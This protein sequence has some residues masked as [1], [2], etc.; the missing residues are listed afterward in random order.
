MSN[1]AGLQEEIKWLQDH[2]EFE[3]RPATLLEFLG[4]DYLGIDSKVRGSIKR[5]L[6]IIM[7]EE[8]RADRPT[9][10][11]LAMITG[12]I[13]IGKTTVAS[14]VLPYLCHWVLCLK[15]P[16][17]FFGLLPG[18][19]IAFMQM[20]T[21]EQQAR[22]VVFGDIFARIRH[23]PWFMNKYPFDP[24]FTKSVRFEKD[25]WILPGD[26]A[27]TTFEGYNIL[28][29]IL[30]EAD[31]HKVTKN[32][33][34]ADSG[35][36]TISARITSRFEDKGFLLVIGQ[37]KKSVGFAASK[38]EEF[39]ARDDAYAV[40]MAIWESMGWE[41]YADDD[42]HVETFRYDTKRKMVVPDGVAKH[43]TYTT[44]IIEIPMVFK[45]DFV[46]NPE[47]ALRDLAGIPPVVGDPFISLV[48]KIEE[49]SGRWLQRHPHTDGEG[50]VDP[51][52]RIRRWFKAHD[53]LK[54][55][56]HIDLAYSADGDHLGF[57][58]GHVREMI[59]VED[60]IKPYIIIDMLLRM[61]APSGGEIYLG[62]VRR[63]VYELRDK[64]GF[65]L[66][67]ISM[68]GFESTDTK[69]QFRRKRIKSDIVSIDRDVLPYHDLREAIYEDR[70]EFPPYLVKYHPNDGQL[71]EVVVKE[72]MELVDEG[73][74]IDHPPDGSKDVADAVAG[75]THHLMGDR[76]YHKK[77][78]RMADH[79][80]R[81]AAVGDGTR[82]LHPAMNPGTLPAPIPPDLPDWARP[83]R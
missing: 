12:G 23:S 1:L 80:A 77:V 32:K 14:I 28:G 53:S 51:E 70:I 78:V 49:C 15:D 21:S 59:Q 72:L 9:E 35:Y 65:K 24:K 31:S 66:D 83:P 79:S 36:T 43:T 22:E 5:E 47:K 16:Q 38:F 62:N 52:G 26:S 46:N 29:G 64:F 27:E 50:P 45:N 17:D 67:F 34:Y 54:R 74:K 81:K 68:D 60:E 20:S 71:T 42:G 44:D 8:V 33:D 61:H 30:D 11:S 6:S 56:G 13:G 10:Y 76:R 82:P 48:H 2:P 63:L 25:I 41:H 7:G 55:A 75:V 69:Q 19:R 58:M 73:G 40:R 37:M 18:S 4:E 3:E 57:A 39:K